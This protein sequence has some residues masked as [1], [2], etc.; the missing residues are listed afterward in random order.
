[1]IWLLLI[2]FGALVL[3]KQWITKHIQGIGLLLTQD[4]QI[5]LLIY[6]SLI[7]PG[8]VLH[9]LS[10]ALTAW[11]L[12]VKVGK[13]SIGIKTGRTGKRKRGPVALGSVEIARTDPFRSSLIGLAPLVAGSIVVLL[14]GSQV[15]GLRPFD[16][17]DANRLWSELQ[18][19]RLK[20]S[21][22]HSVGNL[23]HMLLLPLQ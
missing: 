13:L 21:A 4:G 9:E 23:R 20:L 3:L 1:M 18:A 22:T 2:L 10:H 12:G 14:I 11:V 8:V 19:K 16:I 17:S 5:A 7:L 6:F 15:F